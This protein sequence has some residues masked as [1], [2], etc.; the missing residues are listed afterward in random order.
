M[1]KKFENRCDTNRLHP[2]GAISRRG[3]SPHLPQ[4]RQSLNHH[5]SAVR[6]PTAIITGD[7][8]LLTPVFTAEKMVRQI[9]GATL[10]V[11]PGGTH[12]TPVE[13]P[14][15]VNAALEALLARI[16]SHART[17]APRAAIAP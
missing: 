10:T 3:F 6:I 16:P 9:A 4:G 14:A 5:S 13:Y 1:L 15:V 12:Y 2:N 11:I 17:A 8:D 7:K